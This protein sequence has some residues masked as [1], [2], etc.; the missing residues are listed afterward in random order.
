MSLV[1]PSVSSLVTVSVIHNNL[2]TESCVEAQR[3]YTV[4]ERMK[5]VKEVK[6][7]IIYAYMGQLLTKLQH[8]HMVTTRVE[9]GKEVAFHS[10][11][12]PSACTFQEV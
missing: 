10:L 11:P 12:N 7:V 6:G 5:A 4:Q 9:F 1:A 3:M 2:A 8:D